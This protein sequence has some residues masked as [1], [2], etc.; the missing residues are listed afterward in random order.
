MN[1]WA[2]SGVT[3]FLSWLHWRAKLVDSCREKLA[4]RLRIDFRPNFVHTHFS[5][6]TKLGWT[7]ELGRVGLH[8]ISRV[9]LFPC[10]DFCSLSRKLCVH[11]SGIGFSCEIWKLHV[12][13]S[14]YTHF[15][16]FIR[17]HS[18]SFNFFWEC[19]LFLQ[20]YFVC[21]ML[22]LSECHPCITE[23]LSW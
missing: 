16:V 19:Q 8:E 6:D 14:G 2:V 12:E 10:P 1:S 9:M 4:D 5:R 18:Q 11:N 3:R 23:S 21:I 17:L 13:K 15:S 22:Q 20:I 7:F